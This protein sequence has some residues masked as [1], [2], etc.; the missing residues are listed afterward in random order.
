MVQKLLL[1]HHKTWSKMFQGRPGTGCPSN[2]KKGFFIH[3]QTT[4]HD[5]QSTIFL[6][7]FIEK[8]W[9]ELDSNQRRR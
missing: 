2:M 9:A 1:S 3:L 4:I 5:L 8:W 6:F 7:S